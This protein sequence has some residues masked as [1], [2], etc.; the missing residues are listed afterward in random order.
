MLGSRLLLAAAAVGLALTGTA[1]AR[2]KGVT[3]R[4]QQEQACYNDAMTLCKDAVPD[5]AK[6]TA[7]MSSKRSQLSPMCGKVFDE[8]EKSR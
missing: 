4:Q 5:E 6:I 2:V 7:C 8:G 1:S 3:Q